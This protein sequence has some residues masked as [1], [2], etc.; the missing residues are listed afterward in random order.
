MVHRFIGPQKIE[1]PQK[2]F[3]PD[4]VDQLPG[5]QAVTE[6]QT[7]GVAEMM[8]KMALRI[9]VALAKPDQIVVVKG[10][11]AQVF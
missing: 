11:L 8:N 9:G 2:R 1:H 4:I 7:D 5:S 3:L 6:G 10:R